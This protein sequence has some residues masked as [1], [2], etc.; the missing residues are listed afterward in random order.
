[1]AS[2]HTVTVSCL[3]L[4]GSLNN[5]TNFRDKF[6]KIIKKKLDQIFICKNVTKQ[7]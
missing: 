4:L 1:M 3:K 6:F 7:F 5:S 2:S